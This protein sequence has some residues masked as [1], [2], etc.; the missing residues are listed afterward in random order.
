MPRGNLCHICLFAQTQHRMWFSFNVYCLMFAKWLLLFHYNYALSRKKG[1]VTNK[2][3]PSQ[4]SVVILKNIP[5]YMFFQRRHTNDQ[6]IHKK[7]LNMTNHQGNTNQ[8]QNEIWP[9]FPGNLPDPGIEPGSPALWADSLLSE[10]PR[11]PSMDI[12]QPWE[13]RKSCHLWQH[14]WNLRALR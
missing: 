10:Q 7:V 9:P 13:R 14:S 12:I 1:N 2:S 4:L 11:R 6:Q 8:N 3:H 5:E